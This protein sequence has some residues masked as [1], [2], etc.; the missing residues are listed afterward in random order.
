VFDQNEVNGWIQ[1]YVR[2]KIQRSQ[3]RQRLLQLGAAALPALFSALDMQSGYGRFLVMEL[4]ETMVS[5]FPDPSRTALRWAQQYQTYHLGQTRALLLHCL[6]NT[7]KRMN[8]ADL[9]EWFS[10]Y[11]D[12][13]FLVR[14]AVLHVIHKH[15]DG[16]LTEELTP[17][18]K[19]AALDPHTAVRRMAYAL[20]RRVGILQRLPLGM[21]L[22]ALWNKNRPTPETYRLSLFA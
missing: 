7:L 22:K 10:L 4:I 19:Y 21:R 8:P 15:A 18:L 6:G 3:F 12:R 20:A 14:L 5:K 1:S 13:H 9:S 16:S 17:F 11:R 2:S